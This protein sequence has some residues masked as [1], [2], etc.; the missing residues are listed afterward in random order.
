MTP[1]VYFVNLCSMPTINQLIKRPRKKVFAK[2]K[3]FT[4]KARLRMPFA[5]AGQNLV[6]TFAGRSVEN[7]ITQA[8]GSV[9]GLLSQRYRIGQDITRSALIAAL[10]VPNVIEV[11]LISPK[12][13]ITCGQDEVALLSGEP[14]IKGWEYAA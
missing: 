6:F 1:F 7:Y 4:L 3:T 11:D 8:L 5:D 9:A 10:H 2:E 14:E 13:N 12:E